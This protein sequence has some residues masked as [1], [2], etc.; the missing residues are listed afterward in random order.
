L[1]LNVLITLQELDSGELEADIDMKD[2]HD[3]DNYHFSLDEGYIG[4]S[5]DS[6]EDGTIKSGKFA[7]GKHY[8]SVGSRI[9]LIIIRCSI[10]SRL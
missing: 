10:F 4:M 1:T 7:W 6:L 9:T 3:E 2:Y 8:S 5:P